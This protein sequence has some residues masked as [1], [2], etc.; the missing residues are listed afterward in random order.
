MSSVTN[1]VANKALN[2][3]PADRAKLAHDLIVSVDN[4]SFKN[5]LND[6]IERR[7][8]E[9]K[10]GNAKGRPAEEVLAEIKTKYS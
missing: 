7:V 9:I 8:E 5:V 2:L 3:S 4:T 6:E 1:E 10:N